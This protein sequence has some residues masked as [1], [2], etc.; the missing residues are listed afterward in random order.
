MILDSKG[1]LFGK[2][3][4]IDILILVIIIGGI[5]GV[6]YKMNKSNIATPLTP[7]EKIQMTLYS[8]KVPDYAANAIKVGDPVKDKIG[9]NDLGKVTK[10]EISDSIVYGTNSEGKSVKSSM[11]GF[12]AVKVLVECKG[13]LGK[14]ALTIGSSD[15]WLYKNFDTRFGIAYFLAFVTDIKKLED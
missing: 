10:V 12:K 8:D 9:N 11:E 13:K 7:L 2:I 4:I 1:K 15:Y 5:A 6:Y 14:S 3:S